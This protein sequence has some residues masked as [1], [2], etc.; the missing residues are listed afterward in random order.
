MAYLPNLKGKKN[1]NNNN[2]KC[3]IKIWDDSVLNHMK[4]FELQ[5]N[6]YNSISIWLNLRKYL[7]EGLV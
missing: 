2:G 5:R 1:N 7:T 4:Y 6:K 3:M